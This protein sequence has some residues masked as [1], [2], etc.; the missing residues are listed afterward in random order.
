MEYTK[1]I[2]KSDFEKLLKEKI[3]ILKE[4]LPSNYKEIVDLDNIYNVGLFLIEDENNVKIRNN[5]KH[6]KQILLFFDELEKLKDNDLDARYLITLKHECLSGVGSY[7]SD[8]HNYVFIDNW[9]VIVIIFL[10]IDVVF[11]A[12][13][14]AKYYYYIPIF[15]IIYLVSK[16]IINRKAKKTGKY[17][18]W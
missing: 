8:K 18:S 9:T 15:T 16:I 3:S 7:L 17:I 11:A 6:K 1:E 10:V 13:G 5:H 14:L 4:V 12:F 2:V